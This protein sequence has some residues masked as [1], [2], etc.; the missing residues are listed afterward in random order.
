MKQRITATALPTS[1]AEPWSPAEKRRFG[2]RPILIGA[3]VAAATGVALVLNAR[4]RARRRAAQGP[5]APYGRSFPE[6]L[7]SSTFALVNRVV[8]WHRLPPPLSGMNLYAFRSELREQNLHDTW[9][10]EAL[11]PK[12]GAWNPA[13]LTTR[14][15]DGSYNDLSRP[16]MGMC[17]MRFGRNVPRRYTFPDPEPSL[18]EPSPREVSRRLLARETFLPARS[19]NV[20]AAAWIQFQTHDWFSHGGTQHSRDADL[21]IPVADDDPWFEKP[22]RLPRSASD[23]TRASTEIG[24][25]PTY[26]NQVSHWWDASGIYGSDEVTAQRIRTHNDGKLGVKEGKLPIDPETG[27]S[28]TGFTNNWWLGLALL[29]TL[30]T[31]EHNAI[32]DRLK[33]EY[34]NWEDEQLYQTARLINAALIAKIHTLEWTPGILAHPTLRVGMATNWWGLVTERVTRLLGRL[35][36]SEIISGIPG[37]PTDHHGALFA[38]TEEFTSVYRLHAL[39]PDDYTFYSVATG[40]Q[41]RRVSF[42]E[43][44]L[45]NANTVLG[46]DVTTGDAF[47]SLGVEHPGAITLHNFPKALRDFVTPDG[48][49]IDLAAVDV[50]R[51]R[52]RGVPR[53]NQFRELIHRQP[54]RTFEELTSNP[55]WAHQ[56]REVYRGDVDR[57]DLMVGM[58]AEDLPSGFGFSDTAFRI[59][60]LM[61]SRRLKSDRFFT[62]DFTP[63]VYTQVGLNWINDSD[64]SAVLL[65]HYPEL[66][67]ALH[68][69]ANAFAPWN[70]VDSASA[71][72]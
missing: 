51:D 72:H 24:T 23:P 30:F 44:A 45:K 34:P 16:E 26:V 42:L 25:P 52:E 7:Y 1:V 46:T 35:S 40:A 58:F 48:V 59:F 54:I 62:K 3:A 9:S 21:R 63:R 6:R 10:P 49:R 12:P 55:V 2:T 56:L 37:S 60:I 17:G 4:A 33:R 32:C 15:L 5:L 39:I 47:Y 18:M 11:G 53:Y 57:V 19:L 70:R 67:P 14:T 64:M 8:P 66:A 22:M 38:L 68:G 61:A 50:T 65:R 41:I 29:H 43:V 71:D 31:L 36:D 20:L 27:L 69:V 13:Y 28:I